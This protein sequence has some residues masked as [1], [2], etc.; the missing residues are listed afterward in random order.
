[1]NVTPPLQK[2]FTVINVVSI[3]LTTSA[4]YFVAVVVAPVA[5][6]DASV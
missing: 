3:A 6:S 5:A 1:M 2:P 4:A